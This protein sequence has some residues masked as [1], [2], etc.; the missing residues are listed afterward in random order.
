VKTFFGRIFR[1]N[2]N[3]LAPAGGLVV[4]VVGSFLKPP[5]EEASFRPFLLFLVILWL[6]V[7]VYFLHG[8][9]RPK[10]ARLWLVVTLLSWVAVFSFVQLYF[11][12]EKSWMSQYNGHPVIIGSEYTP[13]GQEHVSKY[14]DRSVERVIMDFIGDRE[15]I[16]T[17][18]SLN[19][20]RTWL[21]GLYL[22][23]GMF[24][25]T[26]MTAAVQLIYC[27]R[28]PSRHGRSPV[29]AVDVATPT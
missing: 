18:E 29:A 11:H 7:G 14:P 4:S 2:W 20:R 25:T 15:M 9:R 24:I 13:K 27:L 3:L 8:W 12:L 6:A 22:L 21:G 10:D 28:V 16:W 19:Q 23:C 5:P 26:A 17:R 1:E